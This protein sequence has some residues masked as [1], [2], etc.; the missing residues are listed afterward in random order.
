MIETLFFLSLLMM[1]L[2]SLIRYWYITLPILIVAWIIYIYRI[3]TK[4][5]L[6]E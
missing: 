5:N 3:K 4:K 6:D 1:I 2:V